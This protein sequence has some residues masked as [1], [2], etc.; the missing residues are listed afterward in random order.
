MKRQFIALACALAASTIVAAQSGGQNPPPDDQQKAPE[1][2]LT[3]CLTQGSG[4]TVFI[5]DNAKSDP[6]NV[7]EKGRTFIVVE[8]TEDLGLA[9]HVN[10]EL[11]LTGQAEAKMVPPPAP[12][13]KVGEKDLPK[14]Q[15]KTVKMVSE[16]C[17]AT[18]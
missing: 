8:A 9:R 4:P 5:F 6:K 7:S 15:V 18:R 3:G 14:F 11:A 2:T 12:G 16:S 10:H 17:T 13:Q 1:V